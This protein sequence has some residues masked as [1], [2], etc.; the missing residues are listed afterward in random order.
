VQFDGEGFLQC[1]GLRTLIPIQFGN[2]GLKFSKVVCEFLLVLLQLVELGSCSSQGIQVTKSIVEN[3]DNILNIGK[4]KGG[5]GL[6]IGKNLS[7]C[8]ALK[9][10][11]CIDHPQSWCREQ[12]WIT[13]QLKPKLSNKSF[14]LLSISIEYGGIGDLATTACGQCGGRTSTGRHLSSGRLISIQ[15]GLSQCV[16]LLI[17]SLERSLWS[18]G[19]VTRD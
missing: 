10:V 4:G 2:E 6:D 19:V 7:L 16:E 14:N 5:T 15:D 8:T 3:T 13:E 11:E 18:K 9:S 12:Y 17:G 1:I